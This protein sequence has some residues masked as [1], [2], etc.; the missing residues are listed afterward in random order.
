[1][2]PASQHPIILFDG[3]CNLCER[4]VQFVIR[5]DS[6]SVFRF[7]PLQSETAQRLLAEFDYREETLSSV[8]LIDEGQVSRK[9]QAALRIARKLDG[10]WPVL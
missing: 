5:Y 7:A 2:D 6:K 1:V 8:L 10:A 3:V 4:S 9:S